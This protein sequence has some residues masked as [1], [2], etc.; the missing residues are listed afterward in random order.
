MDK[1]A[2]NA[3]AFATPDGYTNSGL[4]KRQYAAIHFAATI[5]PARPMDR[6]DMADLIEHVWASVDLL[7]D[8]EPK[9]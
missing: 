2:K 5:L 4:T 8:A 9:I 7:L 6:A 1:Y 3:P